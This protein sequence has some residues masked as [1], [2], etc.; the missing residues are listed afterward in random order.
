MSFFA[1]VS[2]VLIAVPERRQGAKAPFATA[3]LRAKSGGESIFV[4]LIAFGD[5]ADELLEHAA[6]E[7]VSAAGRGEISTWAAKDG[8]PQH[9]L[10]IVVSELISV[11]P[12]RQPKPQPV[13]PT[14]QHTS[15]RRKGARHAP[16]RT[17]DLPDDRLDN[18]WAKEGEP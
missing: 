15:K 17:S 6:G 9:G 10:K 11:R 18:L 8:T 14:R 1:L 7:P 3:S 13:N 2:G 12:K 16:P 4:S 5:K